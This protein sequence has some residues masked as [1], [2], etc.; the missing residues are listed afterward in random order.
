L[1][2]F[3]SDDWAGA[4]VSTRAHP[5][6][7]PYVAAAG[8]LVQPKGF[9]DLI[10]AM[11][12]LSSVELRIA[13]TGPFEP[14][15]RRLADAL[16]NVRF[17]GMLDT[18]QIAELFRGAIT[19]A[20]P[21][22]SY[23][24]FGYVTLESFAVETPVVARRLG[25]LREIVEESGGG[26]LF[27]TEDELV[28]A[29]SQLVENRALRNA[30]GERGRESVE[31]IWSETTQADAYVRLVRALARSGTVSANARASAPVPAAEA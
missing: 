26:L 8:R 22:L 29:I 9:Q 7:R 21:S 15:L 2:Y 23:E 30:L 28:D 3:L 25:A 12:R 6:E 17:L 27:D 24:T 14:E 5:V 16:P 20:L 19:V 18:R 4:A 11:A 31:T 10:A 13:G 1:P